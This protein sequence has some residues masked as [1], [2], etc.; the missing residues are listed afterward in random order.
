MRITVFRDNAACSERYCLRA[1][2]V[3]FGGV[4]QYL[5]RRH[6]CCLRSVSREDGEDGGRMRLSRVTEHVWAGG[7][8]L[9]VVMPRVIVPILACHF[10]V[11]SAMC[12]KTEI[13]ALFE[14]I[15]ASCLACIATICYLCMRL[16]ADVSAYRHSPA[17]AL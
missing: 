7:V 10:S 2:F 8:G 1:S 5:S 17:G 11:S 13:S 14:I 4:I 9:W 12:L 6:L 3:L 15:L 16:P